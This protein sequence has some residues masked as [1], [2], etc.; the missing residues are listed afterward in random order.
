MV[1]VIPVSQ[2]TVQISAP[3]R[4]AVQ[5][6]VVVL[7]YTV[8]G[9]FKPA[10]GLPPTGLHKGR[11]AAGQV[12]VVKVTKVGR[13]P[14]KKKVSAVILRVTTKGRGEE[15]RFAAYAVGGVDRGTASAPIASKGKQTSLVVADVGDK[16]LIALAASSRTKVKVQIVGYVTK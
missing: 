15:G 9:G 14:K 8:G 4:S 3:K 13:V 1:R 5:V 6:R 16:G 10:V 12:K 7:G 2:G 11:F